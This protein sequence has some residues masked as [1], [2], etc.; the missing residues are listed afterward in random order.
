MK[1][2]AIGLLFASLWASASVATKVGLRS[3][4]P[5]VIT[6]LRFF[7][8]GA[9]M[10]LWAHVIRRHR[11]PQRD[12]WGPLTLYGALNCTI[13]LAAFALAMREVTAGVGTLAV[14]L[15]PLLIGLLSALWLRKPVS[16]KMAAGLLL[17]VLGVAL[18]AWPA[19]QQAQATPRGVATLTFGI[20][21]YS[22]GNVYYAGRTWAL[23]RIAINGWQ[24]FLAAV[25]L[26]PVTL[27]T[28]T[29][30]H[31]HFDRD[32]WI[33]VGWLAIPVS[34]GAVSMWL[35]LLKIDPVK[36]SMWLFVCPLLGFLYAYL[37]LGEPFTVFAMGGTGLVISGLYL[38]LR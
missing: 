29:W 5:L 33:S 23:P 32:F 30:E 12:E 38:G 7:L 25:L 3:G 26:L 15:S 1:H 16:I 19:L 24:V 37:L 28:S 22:V 6:N 9:L 4:E 13:Y 11:W 27:L 18:A 36:A 17:G 34:I 35:Y 31:N 20:V 10:L 21:S 8:A 14:G 2:L